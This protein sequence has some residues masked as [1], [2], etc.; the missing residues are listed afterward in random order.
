MLSFLVPAMRLVLRRIG[1]VTRYDT[2]PS[3]EVLGLEYRPIETTI[4][5]YGHSLVFHGLARKLPGYKPPSENW[6]PESA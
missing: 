5:D 6:S 4:S 1:K 3:K 2:T